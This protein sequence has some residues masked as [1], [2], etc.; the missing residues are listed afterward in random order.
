MADGRTTNYTVAS[1]SERP[2]PFGVIR[3][4]GQWRGRAKFAAWVADKR[5]RADAQTPWPVPYARWTNCPRTTTRRVR[6][7][8]SHPRRHRP[9]TRRRLPT[10]R[11]TRA[12]CS[13]YAFRCGWRWL[14][15]ARAF[16]K[17]L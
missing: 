15:N 16:R 6:P 1:A 5:L 2:P 12:V 7:R 10:C 17:S 4:S 13:K 9:A 3:A 14:R 11:L 8:R